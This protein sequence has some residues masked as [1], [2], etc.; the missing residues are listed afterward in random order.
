[1]WCTM[2]ECVLEIKLGGLMGALSHVCAE[3]VSR[4]CAASVRD[5]RG[6]TATLC[7]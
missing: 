4:C 2:S 6:D 1:M 7:K 3:V 5:Y